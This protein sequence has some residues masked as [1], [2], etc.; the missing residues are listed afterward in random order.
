MAVINANSLLKWIYLHSM[1][2][3]QVSTL[4]IH[5]IFAL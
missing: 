2:P 3:K 5:V 1:N 4:D